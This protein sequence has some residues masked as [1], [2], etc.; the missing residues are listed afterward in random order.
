MNKRRSVFQL[1][2]FIALVLLIVAGIVFF[3]HAAARPEPGSVEDSIYQATHGPIAVP[4]TTLS[5]TTFLAP[6]DSL[7]TDSTLLDSLM[8]MGY[9]QQSRP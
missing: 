6:I 8:R 9:A 7:P 4:D 2:L 5:D 3:K 1:S